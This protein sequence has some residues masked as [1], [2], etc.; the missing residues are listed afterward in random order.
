MHTAEALWVHVG[1][2]RSIVDY[3]QLHKQL[4]PLSHYYYCY[5]TGS[6]QLSCTKQ[7]IWVF[8]GSSPSMYCQQ[9]TGLWNFSFTKLH[10]KHIVEQGPYRRAVQPRRQTRAFSPIR[11]YI[12]WQEM[13]ENSITPTG[14]M[15]G[16]L[17]LQAAVAIGRLFKS[18]PS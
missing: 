5:R 11:I 10:P 17:P 4:F 15:Q 14:S 12:I 16:P 7:S 9:K 6:T 13:T 2:W 1:A 3:S 8:S 18:L